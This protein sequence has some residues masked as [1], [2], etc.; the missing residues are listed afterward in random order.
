M[1]R[2][3]L[4]HPSLKKQW[5]CGILF[6][7]GCGSAPP[8]SPQELCEGIQKSHCARLYECATTQEAQ[9]ALKSLF[10]DQDDCIQQGFNGQKPVLVYGPKTM[11]A[12]ASEVQRGMALPRGPV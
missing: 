2:A 1:T 11:Y 9:A 12:A 3:S 10:A 8:L 6:L 4:P 7:L 5:L